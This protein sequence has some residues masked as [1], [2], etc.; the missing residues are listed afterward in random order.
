MAELLKY[1]KARP[2]SFYRVVSHLW[3]RHEDGSV[4]TVRRREMD[5]SGDW[6]DTPENWELPG[7]HADE[8]GELAWDTVERGY[9]S[10][11]LGIVT[12]H[13]TLED[14]GDLIN[15]LAKKFRD[16]MYYCD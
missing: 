9:F 7:I 10:E 12:A 1:P 14:K 2:D 3:L 11:E 4:E 15:K 13:V 8:W 6:V 16:A 5:Q